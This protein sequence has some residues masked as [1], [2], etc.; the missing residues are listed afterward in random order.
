MGENSV[1]SG[2]ISAD[3]KYSSYNSVLY[4]SLSANNYLVIPVND[5][6]TR[7]GPF[8]NGSK[9]AD[10]NH[11]GILMD[12]HLAAVNGSLERLDNKACI[13]AYAQDYI[14]TRSNLLLVA[15]NESNTDQG[16]YSNI[17]EVDNT[18]LLGACAIDPYAWIC[19][20]NECTRTC[21][22]RLSGVLNDTTKWRPFNAKVDFCLSQ[23]TPEHCKLEFS[24]QILI[25]VLVFNFLKAVLMCCLAFGISDSPLMTLGD[26]IASFTNHVDE[27]TKGSCLFSKNNFE[28]G[29]SKWE[30]MALQWTE[31]RVRWARAASMARW[32]LC[33]ML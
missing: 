1:R 21:H 22:Y 29:Q 7:A 15:N 3:A 9:K 20:T 19:P 32:V 4:T 31:T 5:A 2:G 14:S 8:V 23:K 6:F 17:F 30:P 13:E 16:V 27:T 26:A 10:S 28:Y 18:N 24:V 11:T 33:A 25:V 12:L